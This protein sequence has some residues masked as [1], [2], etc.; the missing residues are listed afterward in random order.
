MNIETLHKLLE[1]LLSTKQKGLLFSLT[2]IVKACYA[3]A[4][5]VFWQPTIKSY[6]NRAYYFV[7][8]SL[9]WCG[10]ILL[11]DM[12]WLLWG[13]DS[14]RSPIWMS[15]PVRLR[16]KMNRLICW[17]ARES[18]KSQPGG[19]R[20]HVC[21]GYDLIDVVTDVFTASPSSPNTS[22]SRKADVCGRL[23]PVTAVRNGS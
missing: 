20:N 1:V 11:W 5:K 18:D 23:P 2:L 19:N 3:I 14:Q 6:K 15:P 21:C 13:K 22:T 7:L 4:V 17:H 9:W 10:K 12:P 16:F 8:W